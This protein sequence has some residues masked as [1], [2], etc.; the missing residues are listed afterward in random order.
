[1]GQVKN[2][3]WRATRASL[4]AKLPVPIIAEVLAKLGAL[5]RD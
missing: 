1:L 5:L 3:D 2:L 4:I